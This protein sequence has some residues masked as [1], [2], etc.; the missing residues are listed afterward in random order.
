MGKNISSLEEPES[1]LSELLYDFLV[2]VHRLINLIAAC[3][4][5]HEPALDSTM[6][7]HKILNAALEVDTKLRIFARAVQLL[8]AEQKP[9][10]ET[11][12]H[13]ADETTARKEALNGAPDG[14][15]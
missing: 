4:E 13:T 15:S 9:G 3:S 7:A 6:C 2:S 5:K 10:G 1:P 11:H 8:E 14:N 12:E